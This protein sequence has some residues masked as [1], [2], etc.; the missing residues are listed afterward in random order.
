MFLSFYSIFDAVPLFTTVTER[1]AML[2]EVMISLARIDFNLEYAEKLLQRERRP[3][4]L[5]AMHKQAYVEYIPY[6]IIGLIVPSNFPFQNVVSHVLDALT[7][8]NSCLVKLSEWGCWNQ[9]YMQRMF[10]S[11]LTACGHSPELVQFCT[12][13]AETGMA[14]VD[15]ADKILFIGSTGV[16]KA[17]QQRAAETWTPVTLELGGKDAFVV[18]DDADV[19]R[20]LVMA[21]SAAFF[22]LGQNCIA[23]ERFIVYESVYEKFKEGFMRTA[24]KVRQGEDSDANRCDVGA[25]LV[26][27]WM[28]RYDAM[29]RDAEAKGAKILMGGKRDPDREGLYFLPTV[30]EGATPDMMCVREE[31]FGPLAVLMKPVKDDDELLQ[32]LNHPNFGLGLSIFGSQVRAK[33]IA[34]SAK[35]G[36][37][38]INDFGLNQVVTTMPFG[39][40]GESGHGRFWG[41][42]GLRDFTYLKCVVSD[43]FEG[44]A[45]AAPPFMTL[46]ASKNAPSSVGLMLEAF[47]ASNIL[48]QALGGLR[49]AKRLIS[50]DY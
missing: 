16:G 23:A 28:K 40:V 17:V 34:D 2:G 27:D 1:E 49:L 29:I 46:P 22:N 3:V 10:G 30:I 18:L 15:E 47:F 36:M 19:D 37:V 35:V 26:P 44:M 31:T 24:L 6:G 8:G 48:A 7:A 12:G 43:R 5:M 13:Y 38:G 20:A 39:G 33:R 32:V 25:V 11:I 4:G 42:E 45:P 41:Y 9:L 14:I 50:K 21:V